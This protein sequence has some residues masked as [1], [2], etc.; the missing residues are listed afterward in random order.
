MIEFRETLFHSSYYQ[1]LERGRIRF[2]DRALLAPLPEPPV[3]RLGHS[4]TIPCAKWS[5]K[6]PLAGGRRSRVCDTPSAALL[7]GLPAAVDPAIVWADRSCGC[8]FVA[9]A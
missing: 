6:A 4:V 1:I 5:R 8:V 7:T 2:A 9:M 3:G